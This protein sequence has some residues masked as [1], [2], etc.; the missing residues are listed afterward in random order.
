[1]GRAVA[2]VDREVD[3]DRHDHPA[4]AGQERQ[5]DAPP[6]AQLAEVELTARLEPDHEEE[7]RHQPGVDPAAQV[8]RD[9]GAADPDRKRRVPHALVR[10]EVRVRPDQRGDDAGEKDG[11]A[12]RLRAEECAERAL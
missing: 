11:G 1:M 12:A 5:R 8:L 9:A 7:E 6:L 10:H 3:R 4:D 2:G